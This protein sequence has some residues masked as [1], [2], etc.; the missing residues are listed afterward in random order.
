MNRWLRGF[1]YKINLEWWMFATSAGLV[2][3]IAFLT[4]SFQTIK[5]AMANPVNS[6]RVE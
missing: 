6:L 3:T 4:L 1:A 2:L 5:S